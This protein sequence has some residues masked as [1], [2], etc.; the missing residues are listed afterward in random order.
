MAVETISITKLTQTIDKKFDR[1]KS[2]S[3]C[4]TGD[5]FQAAAMLNELR[6][7]MSVETDNESQ[8]AQLLLDIDVTI[9]KIFAKLQVS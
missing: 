7:S 1:F 4:G 9:D 3:S 8:Y 6:M 2:F 5:Y